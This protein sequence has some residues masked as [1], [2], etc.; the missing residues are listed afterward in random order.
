LRLNS[1]PGLFIRRALG[2]TRRSAIAV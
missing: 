2:R 1:A